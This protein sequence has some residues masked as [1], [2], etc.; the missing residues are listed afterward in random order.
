MAQDDNTPPPNLRG[1]PPGATEP[2]DHVK[3]P[4]VYEIFN[5]STTPERSHITDGATP[6]TTGP[7]GQQPPRAP[8]PTFRDGVQS[9]QKDDFFRLHHIP[10]AR[11]GFMTGIGAGAV[12]GAGR[13]ITGARAPKAANWAFGAFFLGSIVQWEYCQ[14][15]RRKERAAMARV[16]EVMDR[17]QAEKKTQEEAARLRRQAQER[18][19][20]EAEKRWYKF[21]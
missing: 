17:K 9:I 1:P 12:V 2:P 10:C 3:Q 19:R 11:E 7:E 21:W 5:S 13:F 16:V 15:Q 14:A 18:A 8:R 20:L 6:P 4:Q